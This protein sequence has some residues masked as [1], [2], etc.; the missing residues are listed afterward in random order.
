MEWVVADM[1]VVQ[2]VMCLIAWGALVGVLRYGF[3]L[4]LR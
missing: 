3:G 2:Y 1:S 4:M